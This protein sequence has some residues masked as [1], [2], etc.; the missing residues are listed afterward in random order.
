[1]PIVTP[2]NVLR[3]AAYGNNAYGKPS[4]GY[5][6]VK[7]L[8][9]DD[10]FKKCLHDYIERWH[11]KHPIPWDFFYSFNN[12]AGQN[13]NWFWNNWYFT[14]NYIDLAVQQVT[15]TTGGYTLLI[16]NIGGY[17]APTNVLITYTDGSKETLHQT[18]AIWSSNQKE[19]T[20]SIST[21]KK[22]KSLRLN[23]GIFMDANETD[24]NWTAP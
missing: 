9:G 5:L 6:A 21:Q 24:N 17:P 13:L 3:G 8:L 15:A 7:D 19:A 12:S 4:L 22:I 10:L 14:N 23:G 2:A 1:M 16:K 11:G 20:V 18:P